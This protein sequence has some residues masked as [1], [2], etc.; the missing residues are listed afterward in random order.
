MPFT[1]Y[2]AGKIYDHSLAKT[3]WTMPTTVYLSL[4]T[5]DPTAAGTG[6]EVSGGGYARKALTMGA[7]T[8]GTGANSA[9]VNFGTAS[10]SWG[11]VTHWAIW[12]ALTTGNPLFYGALTVSK[13]VNSGDPVTVPVGDVDIVI[14]T[15]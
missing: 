8:N 9:L 14:A 11:T 6:A 5:A 7:H 2:G 10:A 12:D 4:H 3:S 15:S 13:V 1:N